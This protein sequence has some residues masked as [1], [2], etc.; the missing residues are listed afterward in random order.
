MVERMYAVV[1]PSEADQ[2]AY[3]YLWVNEDRT[4]RELHPAERKYLETPFS[5]FDGGRPYIKGDFEALD[6]WGSIK[7]FCRRA[8]IPSNLSIGPAPVEDPNPPMSKAEFVAFLKKKLAGIE[9]REVVEMPDG[10]IHMR[11][12]GKQ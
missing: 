1:V 11:H 6:G 4:V 7:G 5:P 9:G 10:T 12:V 3:P 8:Q 2:K